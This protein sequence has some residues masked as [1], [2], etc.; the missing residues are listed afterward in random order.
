MNKI[1][2]Y[3]PSLLL[4]ATLIAACESF[5]DINTNRQEVTQEMQRRDG[6]AAGGYIQALERQ[7]VPVGTAANKTDII[8]DY[9][10]AYHLGADTWSG[11]FSQ[12]ADWGGGNNHTTYS[13]MNG[14]ISATFTETYKKAFIPW[15]AIKAN[16][17]NENNPEIY[18]LAQVL[19]IAAWQK[20]TDCFGPIPYTK[21]GQGLLVTPYDSQEVVY[22]SMLQDLDD[23][24]KALTEYSNSSALIFKEYD[25]IYSG[26][27]NK[28]IKFANSLMLRVAMRTRFADPNLAKK[29]AELAV[30]HPVGV[31]TEKEDGASIGNALGLQFVNPIETF[32]VQ[33][34]ECRMGASVFSYLAG[35]KDPRL[36]K[37]F[38][39]SEDEDATEL[40][41]A[42]G[43]YYPLG[44]GLGEKSSFYSSCSI[45]NIEKNTPV[46]WLLTSEVYFLRAEGALAGWNMN[47]SAD[48]L[49]K[50][51]IEMS[52]AENGID[53]AKADDYI[54]SGLVPADVEAAGS[55]YN[56][57]STATVKFEGTDEEK[58]EK[59]IIQKY[60][61]LYPNGQEA[62]SEF[63]R[64]GY[65][66]LFPVEYNASGGIVD[67]NTGA[68]RYHYFWPDA[69]T[70]EEQKIYDE[71]LTLLGGDDTA[72]T[73]LWW[74]KK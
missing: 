3:A 73:K 40:D 13:L 26:N 17:A 49:Y 51:G 74:D 15:L 30:N 53:A 10:I 36:P 2:K 61:A 31:M 29:Y 19:K 45:P 47:D 6:A 9:Q 42:N 59:I 46:N 50:A 27:L 64:T 25:L 43:K 5:E 38:R 54:N 67:S 33:Y 14:W 1:F 23:A 70:A 65:P 34:G 18:A 69:R 11:Y 24:I 68:R 63:R 21:A 22:K 7:V 48:N 71:A 52:F 35:Y 16:P 56:A 60:I 62:W 72:A 66:K 58:L 37:F 12:N 32:A 55:S 20:A 4:A 57:L 8:N 41:W 44:V 28:W 39:T